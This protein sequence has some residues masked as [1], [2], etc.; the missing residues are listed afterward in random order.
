MEYNYQELIE[1]ACLDNRPEMNKDYE[2]GMSRK[3]RYILN[4]INSQYIQ[5]MEKEKMEKE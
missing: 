4:L 2:T 1:K 3:D 5:R